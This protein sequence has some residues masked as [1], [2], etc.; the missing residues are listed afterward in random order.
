MIS[1]LK[2]YWEEQ[3]LVLIMLLSVIFR[4][5]AVI[6]AKGWGMFDDH[7]IVI[8]SSGSWTAGHDYND[9]LPGSKL[10][11]GPTGHNFFYPGL[12]YLL[13]SLLNL[14]GVSDPQVKMLIVRFLHGCL[15]LIT[16]WVGYRLAEQL[17]GKKVARITGLLLAILWFMPW[18]SVRNLV[19]MTSIPFLMLAYWMML[20]DRKRKSLFLSFFVAGFFFGLAFNIRPQTVFFPLGAGI[21]ILFQKKWRELIALTLGS[22]FMVVLIQGGIDYFIWGKPFAEMLAYVDVCFTE[23]NDYI[24]LPWYNYFLTIGGLLIPPV[25]LF[26]MY[27]FARKWKKYLIIFVPVMLFF[28]FHSYFPNKQERFILPMIPFLILVGV[29]GWE[30]FVNCSTFWKK[31]RV[32][33]HSCWIFFW[34]INTILLVVFSFTYSKKAR[35]EAMTYLSKYSDI[36]AIAV[37]DEHNDP[38]LM[39]K[40]Y[41]NQWP[42]C[43]SEISKDL[44]AD[45]ILATAALPCYQPPRFILFTGDKNI[46]PLVE[47]ARVYFPRLV[48]E[49]TIEPGFIDRFVHWLNP[50]NK[51]RRIFIYRNAALIPEETIKD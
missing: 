30:E 47:K 13:F 36:K 46:R 17:E 40:F 50:V 41:L 18:M 26:L 39:P 16:V 3:P 42:L 45:S 51:N 5:I 27:G 32:L 21:V 4:M 38:E 2:K 35:V 33:L 8:E 19:E 34:V 20:G 9:W 7:F 29:S 28:I 22:V 6:F 15:S 11:H 10:N 48:Y 31:H 43:Y 49:T 23:R 1:R 24:S 12:H 14:T 25:S 37:V 44:S